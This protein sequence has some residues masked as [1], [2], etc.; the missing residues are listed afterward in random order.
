MHAIIHYWEYV[1]QCLILLLLIVLPLVL[2]GCVP[3]ESEPMSGGGRFDNQRQEAIQHDNSSG[4]QP[5]D[6]LSNVRRIIDTSDWKTYRNEEYGFEIK[7]PSWYSL[8]QRPAY[9]DAFNSEL[10]CDSYNNS[11]NKIAC[12]NISFIAVQIDEYIHNSIALDVERNTCRGNKDSYTCYV[13]R[14]E[15]DH[16]YRYDKVINNNKKFEFAVKLNSVNNI[17]DPRQNINL[18]LQNIFNPQDQYLINILDQIKA[19]MIF[20]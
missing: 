4:V 3:K 16:F 18:L 20:P 10:V 5:A 8:K 13:Y 6:S 17:L 7:Y 15:G 19:S 2:A 1:K 12:D 9:G 14:K 11:D